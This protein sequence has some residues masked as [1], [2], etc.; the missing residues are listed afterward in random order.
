M[1]NYYLL[2]KP[3]IIAGNLITLG[4]GFVLASKGKIDFWLFL[5]TLLGLAFIIASA[6]VF[7][8]YIDRHLDQRMERTK[9]RALAKGL[10]SGRNAIAFAFLLGG[11]GALVLTL[12]TNPLT[13]LVASIGFFVYVVL[14]SLWK[15]R[16]IYGTAIGSIAGAI[17]PVVGYCAV[18]NQLDI[19][20]LV[21]FA[22]LVLWQMPHFFS[23]AMFHFDDYLKADIPVL[24]IKKGI[25]RTKVHMTLYILGFILA[26]LSLT[27]FDYT[28]YAYLIVTV[29]LGLMWLGLCLQGFLSSN[30]QIWGQHMF[31]LSLLTIMAV[32]FVIPFD[33]R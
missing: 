4:A 22:M 7:N 15:G 32:C 21:L 6:C 33:V 23:I 27:F 31:R 11:I 2:T 14:Y 26:A 9:G 28:G 5:E 10:I 3:G 25:M 17:P 19:G 24:P 12:F 13:V 8:N 30:D 18:R 1:I 16:T 29:S 20:A